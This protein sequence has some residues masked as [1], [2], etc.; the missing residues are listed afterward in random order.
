MGRCINWG[1]AADA[2]RRRAGLSGLALRVLPKRRWKEIAEAHDGNPDYGWRNDLEARGI[3]EAKHDYRHGEGHPEASYPKKFRIPALKSRGDPLLD[4]GRPIRDLI[5]AAIAVF[6]GKREAAEALR[7]QARNRI[8]P[9]G[10]WIRPHGH[11]PRGGAV[12]ENAHGNK[13]FLLR[14]LQEA[15]L[16]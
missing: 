10:P 5:Q 12:L 3:L 9:T 11:M 8:L 7:T 15:L 2:S 13:E 6:G 14:R 1:V 4:D 16:A